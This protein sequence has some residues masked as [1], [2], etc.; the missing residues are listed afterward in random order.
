MRFTRL[1]KSNLGRS[2]SPATRIYGNGDV[3]VLSAKEK[4]ALKQSTPT[5]T[6]KK[7]K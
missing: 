2:S 6:T 4:K 3:R 7:D 1:G 5:D